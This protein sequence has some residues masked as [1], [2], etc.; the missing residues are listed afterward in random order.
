M[1]PRFQANTYSKKNAARVVASRDGLR[2]GGRDTPNT[3]LPAA[4]RLPPTCTLDLHCQ[5]LSHAHGG[6]KGNM[7][8]ALIQGNS[9]RARHSPNPNCKPKKV[10]TAAVRTGPVHTGVNSNR[11][12]ITSNQITAWVSHGNR[13]GK[14]RRKRPI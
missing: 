6:T 12:P 14:C 10:H 7:A 2:A 5:S 3:A 11:G 13:D 9:P 1:V 4:G 8:T